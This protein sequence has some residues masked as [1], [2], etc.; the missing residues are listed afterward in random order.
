MNRYNII[1]A[2]KEIIKTIVA[3]SKRAFLRI[4]YKE[5]FKL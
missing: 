3:K 5:K 1:N 4:E 2:D